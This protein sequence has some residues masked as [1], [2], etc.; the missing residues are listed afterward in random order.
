MIEKELR[1]RRTSKSMCKV[2]YAMGKVRDS[3][4]EVNVLESTRSE[5]L[6]LINNEPSLCY[7]FIHG[8]MSENNDDI[9]W[10]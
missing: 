3:E 10:S 1:R 5:H 9:N 7:C 2:G 4:L 6:S 8:A